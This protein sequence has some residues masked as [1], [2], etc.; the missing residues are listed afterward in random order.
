MGKYILKLTL[1][2]I[3]VV[4]FSSID[5]YLFITVLI[6][7]FLSYSTIAM[8][9]IFHFTDGKKAASA[10]HLYDYACLPACPSIGHA[11]FSALRLYFFLSTIF[12][13]HL[14]CRFF[15]HISFSFDLFGVYSESAQ[16]MSLTCN[17]RTNEW[18]KE[19]ERERTKCS[20]GEKTR[21]M[22]RMK[23]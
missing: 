15:L 14:Q 3:N 10:V 7:R 21:E 11:G 8:W 2:F 18:A 20:T 9:M 1:F 12:F 4:D 17:D 22:E 16:L 5:S 19:K 6:A 23:R 13:L